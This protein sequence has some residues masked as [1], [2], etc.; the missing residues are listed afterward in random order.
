MSLLAIPESWV[1]EDLIAFLN[2]LMSMP[3]QINPAEIAIETQGAGKSMAGG[4]IS[5]LGTFGLLANCRF[6]E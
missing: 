2:Q 1:V 4:E 3:L 6:R 5:P